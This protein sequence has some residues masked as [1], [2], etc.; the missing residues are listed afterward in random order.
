MSV[1]SLV[2][3]VKFEDLKFSLLGTKKVY[4]YV[5]QLFSADP[6]MYKNSIFEF[7]STI[8]V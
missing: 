1:H 2:Y 4:F 5:N 7:D 6:T 3:R 8:K